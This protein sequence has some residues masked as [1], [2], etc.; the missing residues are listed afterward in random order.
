M[1]ELIPKRLQSPH[2]PRPRAAPQELCDRGSLRA[3]I[4]AGTFH[5]QGPSG[6]LHL[7]MTPTLEVGAAGTCLVFWALGA[8]FSLFRAASR[9]ESLP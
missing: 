4:K 1:T 6:Q 3:A 2:T 7:Q 9:E 8:L 5:K